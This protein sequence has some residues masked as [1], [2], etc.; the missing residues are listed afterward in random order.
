[1]KKIVS[2][3]FLFLALIFCLFCGKKGPIL[4]PLVRA[5]QKAVN[6]KAYQRGSRIVFIWS[7]P[8]AYID[9]SPIEGISKVEIWRLVEDIKP[10][11]KEE[12]KAK[13][14][15]QEKF[16]NDALLLHSF[17]AEKFSEYMIKEDAAVPV[18]TYL[19]DIKIEDIT[20]KKYIFGFLIYD[21]K[22][23]KSEFSDLVTVAPKILTLPPQN[24]SALVHKDKIEVSWT[25]P[26]KNIDQTPAV[27]I[28]GYN[29]YRFEKDEE[30]V[31]L[32]SALIKETKYE[33]RSFSFGV[34]YNYFVRSAADDVFPY[35]E[36]DN[37][38]NKEILA[39]DTFPPS[40]PKGLI[41]VAGR[42]FIALR[43]D[44]LSEGDLRGY[45][46]WRKAEGEKE[47][48]LLTSDPIQETM[49]T[50]STVKERKKYHYAVSGIDE[51]GNES[52]LSASVSEILKEGVP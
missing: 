52:E 20:N 18:F 38:E 19:Y 15:S 23:K 29:I 27:S 26:D 40:V 50:D 13:G 47:F 7:N 36:S 3:F 49:Y 5:P 6:V 30:I 17:E 43:W 39:K 37:S 8:T 11:K 34:T 42:E 16:R 48:T 25:P 2:C 14:I 28:K 33:D 41:A 9:G 12:Q 51:S 21:H 35:S 44:P 1:M 10:K 4:P 46:V 31:K 24:I 32:N 22:G 45:K